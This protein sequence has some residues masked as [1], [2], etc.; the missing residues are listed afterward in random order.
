LATLHRKLAQGLEHEAMGEAAGGR[1]AD[2]DRSGLGERLEPRRDVGR[3]P[4]RD[5]TRF[6]RTDLAHGGLTGVDAH[7]DGEVCE[8]PRRFDVA[9]VLLDDLEDAQAGA[10]SALG[11][12][13]VSGGHAEVRADPVARVRLHH[14]AVLLDGATHHRHALADERL[15]LVGRQP[16]SEGGGADDVGK[17]DRDGA[18]LVPWHRRVGHG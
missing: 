2:G 9:G 8:S 12:V 6:G 17:E 13:I 18:D 7:P 4:E 16:L 14:P 15:H 5:R 3:V 11:I 10:G 1:V